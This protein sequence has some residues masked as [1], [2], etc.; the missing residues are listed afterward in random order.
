MTAFIAVSA[1]GHFRGAWNTSGTRNSCASAQSWIAVNPPAGYCSVGDTWVN[2]YNAP[3]KLALFVKDDSQFC[4]Q[5]IDF[6]NVW[7]DAQ[8]KAN[9]DGAIWRLLC[10]DGFIALGMAVTKSHQ[11][12][13]VNEYRCVRKEFI[14]L[15]SKNQSLTWSDKGCFGP[16]DVR[17]YYNSEYHTIEAFPRE[18]VVS[19]WQFVLPI[20]QL[21]EY[22]QFIDTA[23]VDNGYNA[24]LCC[25]EGNFML[26]HE[27]PKLRACETLDLRDHSSGNP[28]GTCSNVLA[29][30]CRNDNLTSSQCLNFCSIASNFAA[31][32]SGIIEY[33]A[34]QWEKDPSTA[35]KSNVCACNLPSEA[36][37]P[38]QIPVAESLQLDP[39]AVPLNPLCLNQYCTASSAIK[40]PDMTPCSF[41]INVCSQ[42]IST[43]V[44]GSRT[45]A[46]SIHTTLTCSG[47]DKSVNNKHESTTE[48]STITP[49]PVVPK[50]APD[51]N[52]TTAVVPGAGSSQKTILGLYE[53]NRK[54]VLIWGGIVAIVFIVLLLALLLSH[55]SRK[56][57]LQIAEKSQSAQKFQPKQLSVRLAADGDD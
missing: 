43:A 39:H 13:N 16:R 45:G 25:T 54:W 22:I 18:V 38:L 57:Q 3:T 52:S 33:C 42:T 20:E 50:P 4:R 12:P 49:T 37:V 47:A 1:N 23:K 7:D 9:N 41:D 10:P 31:C 5:P 27:R 17:I 15:N 34:N 32:K 24:S 8:T 21:A 40:N 29:G 36:Y 46:N 35:M 56:S 44:G 51:T 6:E 11:K 30:F 26:E 19:Q 53:A 28:S 14:Q 55:K 48:D 2:S